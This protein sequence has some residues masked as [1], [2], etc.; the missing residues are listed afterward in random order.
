[1]L[2]ILN[3]ELRLAM[4]GCGARSLAEIKASSLIDTGVIQRSQPR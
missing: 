1:V 2:Q 3:T 4:V